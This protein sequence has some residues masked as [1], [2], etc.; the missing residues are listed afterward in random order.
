MQAFSATLVREK[1]TISQVAD[2]DLPA[3]SGDAP[4]VVRSNRLVLRL[5]DGKKTE[6]VVIRAQNMQSTLR[7][8]AKVY[9]SFYKNGF[10]AERAVPFD[11]QETWDL[12]LSA[13]DKKFHPRLWC[14]V[15]LDGKAIFKTT[16]T[17]FV[18]VVEKC[19]LSK[20][21]DYDATMSVTEK[22]LAEVG[23]PIRIEHLTKVAAVYSD[24][25]ET[26]RCGVMNRSAGRETTFSFIISGG[27]QSGRVVQGFHI[28]A[29]FIEAVDI[30][31]YVR[32][33][34]R[35]LAQGILTKNAPEMA[36]F[37]ASPERL[38]ELRK[39]VEAFEE[40]VEVK[41]RPER[42]DVFDLPPEMG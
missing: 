41:Y 20:L 14:A 36:R 37:Y 24:D 5:T 42:P 15:Y 19:A 21:S 28:A 16:D 32:S 22:F 6:N 27:E 9:F 38:R 2:D 11:W 8:A 29:A 4:D 12:M 3:G 35:H 17:P 18:D 1:I 23:K 33:V 30:Q 7:Y 26:L 13:Y 39:S 40:N 34:G 10:F 25:N 31:H